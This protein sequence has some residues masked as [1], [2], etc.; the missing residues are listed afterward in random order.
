MGTDWGEGDGTGAGEM[1]Y[2]SDNNNEHFYD[3]LTLAKSKAQWAV[4]KDPEKC[5]KTYNGQNI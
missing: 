2:F 5:I 1:I 4:Q 3:A